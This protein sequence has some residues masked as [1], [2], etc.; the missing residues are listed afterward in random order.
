MKYL[1]T[2]LLTL[3]VLQSYALDF[4]TQFLRGTW[5]ACYNSSMRNGP[6]IPPPV[7]SIFCDCMIDKGRVYF[8]S[9]ENIRNY[10]DNA[11]EVWTNI[12]DDCNYELSQK[13]KPTHA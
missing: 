1:L 12:A 3:V 2:I 6:H 10:A 4:S 8:R 5:T 13:N 7:H 9:E 11:T